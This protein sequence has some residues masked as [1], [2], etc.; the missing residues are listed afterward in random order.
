MFVP[1]SIYN[2]FE[3]IQFLSPGLAAPPTSA[4]PPALNRTF[5]ASTIPH[6]NTPGH[7]ASFTNLNGT[8][9]SR[10]NTP[11][12]I[13][14]FMASKMPSSTMASPKPPL[15]YTNPGMIFRYNGYHMS[16]IFY[17]ALLIM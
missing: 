2:M 8:S 15:Q 3:N 7:N 12:R 4:T 10:F 14:P 17:S 6:Q 13:Q 16:I 9:I 5:P 11:P 1:T